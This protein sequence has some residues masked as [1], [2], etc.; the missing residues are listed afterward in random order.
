M[1]MLFHLTALLPGSPEPAGEV[2]IFSAVRDLIT[3]LTGQ[4]GWVSWAQV[5][6]IVFIALLLDFVQRRVVAILK[7]RMARTDTPWDD[8]ILD[9]VT[10]PVSM[11]I[12]VCGIAQAATFVDIETRFMDDIVVLTVIAAVAWFLTRLIRNAQANLIAS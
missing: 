9:A 10:A 8:A 2:N 7:K 6:S 1:S 5:F 4:G 12:W 3:D 11:L